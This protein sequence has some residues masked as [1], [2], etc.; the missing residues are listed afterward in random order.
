MERFAADDDIL[1]RDLARVLREAATATTA[2]TTLTALA[3]IRAGAGCAA[4]LSG[5]L[6]AAG[7]RLCLL[8][9]RLCGRRRLRSS[10]ALGQHG[11]CP[12]GAGN[13]DA[14]DHA[15]VCG[16]IDSIPGI[17]REQ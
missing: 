4:A 16:H 12:G 9:G 6:P 14:D 2:A 15:S 8:D 7:R 5:I 11:A 10:G 13:D 17:V 1:R 3:L